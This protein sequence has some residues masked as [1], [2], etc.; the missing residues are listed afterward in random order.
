VFYSTV[1]IYFKV[2][3]FNLHILTFIFKYAHM[4]EVHASVGAHKIQKRV[5]DPLELECAA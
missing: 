5:L 2:K 4:G 3:I 1:G